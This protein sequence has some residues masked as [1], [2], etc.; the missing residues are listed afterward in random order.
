[1]KIGVFVQLKPPRKKEVLT[2]QLNL[3]NFIKIGIFFPIVVP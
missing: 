3:L 1:M 2:K